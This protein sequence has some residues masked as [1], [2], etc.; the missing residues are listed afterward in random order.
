MITRCFRILSLTLLV[1]TLAAT[2]V[3]AQT[4][5][6][7][8]LGFV[9]DAQGAVLGGAKVTAINEATGLTRT[10]TT[11]SSGEYMVALLPLGRYTLKFEAEKFKQRAI[12]GVTLELNQKAKIDVS[13]EIGEITE[14]V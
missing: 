7:A 3:H 14:V 6:G 1:I 9:T 2:T 12:R 8:F 10:V 4:T 11:N 5:T 13:L